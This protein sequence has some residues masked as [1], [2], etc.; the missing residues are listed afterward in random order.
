MNSKTDVLII[1]IKN[2]IKGKV[3]T[4]LAKSIG[5]DKALS[6]YMRLLAHT[7][8]IT[9]DLNCSKR[10]YYTWH[11]EQQDDWDNGIYNKQLQYKGDLGQRM[12]QAIEESF[13][14]GFERVCII[15]S[16][17]PELAP[18]HLIQAFDTLK[19]HDAVIGPA[20]D[21]GFYLLGLTRNHADL[22]LNRTWST[23]SVARETIEQFNRLGYTHFQLPTLSDLDEASDLER[24]GF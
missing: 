16:D 13:N 9:K 5:E 8:G 24:L 14:K 11:I 23:S 20:L 19:K 7:C 3:K 4:R 17:C 6:V 12:Y 10:L 18:E 1:F 15:G 22:F 21:G 2:P